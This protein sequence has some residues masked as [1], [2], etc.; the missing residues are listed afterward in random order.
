LNR[1]QR[2]RTEKPPQTEKLLRPPGYSLSIRL[3]STFDSVLNC[4]L[5]ASLFSALSAVCVVSLAILLGANAPMKVSAPFFTVK[6]DERELFAG[7]FAASG[8]KN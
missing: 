3:E 6:C 2:K 4:L 1:C 8:R 7:P 5:A